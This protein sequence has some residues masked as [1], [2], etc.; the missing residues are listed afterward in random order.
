MAR[1]S[2]RKPPLK[3]LRDDLALPSGVRASVELRLL[4]ESLATFARAACNSCMAIASA[5]VPLKTFFDDTA[6][7]S[8]VLGP[9][10]RVQGFH[11][12]IN[13]ACRAFCSSVQPLAMMYP[14]KIVC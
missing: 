13:A 10:E 2:A 8:G 14:F 9:V 12:R 5:A 6:L 4:R 11:E 7:P 3:A 1:I